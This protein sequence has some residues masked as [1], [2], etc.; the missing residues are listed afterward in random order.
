M[1]LLNNRTREISTK[2]VYYGPG[3]SGK[4]TNLQF[5]HNQLSPTTRGDLISM[6]HS[7]R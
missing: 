6:A 7:N 2:I 3:F 1:P 5:I 4:T